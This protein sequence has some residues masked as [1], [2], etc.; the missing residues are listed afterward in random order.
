[1]DAIQMFALETF[2]ER[3]YFI[4]D[5]E[6][7]IA[8]IGCASF[9]TYLT[10]S[11]EE[12]YCFSLYLGDLIGYEFSLIDEDYVWEEEGLEARLT[13]VN[14]LKQLFQDFAELTGDMT[15]EEIEDT[16]EESE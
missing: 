3:N 10:N 15:F 13:K 5:E 14:S 4:T 12:S 16:P 8:S 1:M 2:L 7:T 11:D 6:G 9:S